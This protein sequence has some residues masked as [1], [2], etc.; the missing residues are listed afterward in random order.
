MY[1]YFIRK[2]IKTQNHQKIKI[3][4]YENNYQIYSNGYISICNTG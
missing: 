3:Y 4:S 1:F 2:L